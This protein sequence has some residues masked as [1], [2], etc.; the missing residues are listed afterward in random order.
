MTADYQKHFP[1]MLNEV[2]AALQP[3]DGGVY[4][5]A[6][7]GNGGYSE[8]ILQ[9]DVNLVLTN[10]MFVGFLVLLGMIL[11][12]ILLAVTDPRIKYS[13]GHSA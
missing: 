1:V 6:T 8:A 2:L 4:V 13:G 7:F 12:D 3:E 9:Q 5:D 11:S 10:V